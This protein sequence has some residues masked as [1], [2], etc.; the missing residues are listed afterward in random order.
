MHLATDPERSGKNHEKAWRITRAALQE[1]HNCDLELDPP[2]FLLICL[3]FTK[4]AGAT[5]RDSEKHRNAVVEV[6]GIV[7][8]EFAKLTDGS[9]NLP[10]WIPKL[11]H[12]L[13]G[14][15]L[16]AY[17]RAMGLIEDHVSIISALEWMVENHEDLDAIV[18]QSRNGHEK[19]RQTL[20]AIRF[21]CEDTDYE[22]IAKVLVEKVGSWGGWPDEE[23]VQ[24]YIARGGVR[25][26]DDKGVDEEEGEEIQE[27]EEEE[28]KDS[29]EKDEDQG[30]EQAASRNGDR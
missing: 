27:E 29:D 22:D 25:N 28:D 13:D 6:S 23:E 14:I 16:H 12:G 2:G 7:K 20:I 4:Y 30:E 10:N 18:S 24:R 9:E 26:D 21:I 5:F 1:F 8:A 19:L 11:L 17:V 3:A 15:H